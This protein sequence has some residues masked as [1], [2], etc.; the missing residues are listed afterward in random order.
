MSLKS[1]SAVAVWIFLLTLAVVGTIRAQ[2]SG[3][4]LRGTILDTTGATLPEARVSIKNLDTGVS[5]TVSTN[6][7]G[8]YRAVNLIA[9]HYE[10]TATASGFKTSVQ[11]DVT[12]TVGNET[13]LDLHLEVGTA[14]ETINVSSTLPTVDATSSTLSS[15][16]V[17]ETIRELPLNGRD[18]TSLATLQPGI[19]SIQ[20]QASAGSTSSR[21]NRGWGNQLAVSGHRPQENNYRIDGV[22]INDY[23]NGAPGSAGGVNLGAD[24]IAEFSVLQSNYSAE[25]GRTSGGVINAITKSGTNQL[26]GTGYEF[27]RNAIFDAR[28]AFN[29]STKNKPDFSRHQFGGSAGGP[30]IKDKTFL[31]GDYE[32][33]RQNKGVSRVVTVPSQ[34]ARD[35]AVDAIRP[36]LALWPLPDKSLNADTGSRS[37]VNTQNLTENYFTTRI[38]HYFSLKDSL[39]GT[40]FFDDSN[41]LIPDA[42]NNVT[43]PNQS[44]RQ[45]VAIEETHTF[46]KTFLNTIRVGY[47]RTTGV[48]NG[49]GT[50]LNPIAGDPR[51]GTVPGLPLGLVN[52]P[53]VTPLAGLGSN[54]LAMH[55][56][57]S[58]QFYDDAFVNRGRHSMKFGFASEKI[59]YAYLKAL[60]PNGNWTFTSLANFLQNTPNR[61]AV[62]SAQRQPVYVQETIF[63]GYFADD[64]RVIPRLTLNLGLRYEMATRPTEANGRF[65]AIKN[66]YGGPQVPVESF[67]ET[68]PTLRNFAPRLGLA[69]DPF[70][71]GKTSVRA[72]FGMFDVLPLPYIIAPHPAGDYPFL[73][74]TTV[75]NL[76]QGDFPKNAYTKANFSLVAGT[77]RDPNPK[78][79]YAMNWHL[80]LQRELPGQFTATVGYVGSR[81]LHMAFGAEDINTILPVSQGPDGYVWPTSGGQR[82]NTNVSA[83]RAVFFD[84]S[85]TYH[86]LQAQLSR[87]FSRGFQIQGSYTW[88]KCID[89]GS[90]GPRGDTFTNDLPDLLWFDKAHRR[91]LCSFHVA[92]NFV[93]NGLY[94]IPG[95]NGNS[96]AAALFGGWQLGGIF[97]ASTGT[98]FS[99]LQPGDPL[100]TGLED[101]YAFPDRI[102][103]GG[104]AGNPVTGAPSAYIKECFVPPVPG[105]RMGNAGRNSLI[106]PSL[107]TLNAALYKNIQVR[108]RLSFQFRAEL[109][110]ALNHPNYAYPLDTNTLIVDK[111]GKFTGN[112]GQLTSTQI[113]NRQI[114]FGLRARF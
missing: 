23:S 104:C 97:S 66:I 61:V 17:G 12:L 55:R 68:N 57:N 11:K 27:A 80:T 33:I 65:F 13:T 60:R 1:K 22:S 30:L 18:W 74:T 59:L 108:E 88:S 109:F 8:A 81:S 62:A 41:F 110:N 46:T 14:T 101:A 90:S 95:P 9:G 87:Q 85:S 20:S 4:S 70:G 21:G 93:A 15:V 99:V 102:V 36:Y 49:I 43:F 42:L 98:P 72:G 48:A 58:Y 47:N 45:M 106:G 103:T 63:A 31:F 56:A 79:S 71:T 5:T 73:I 54:T 69:W 25:Y 78:R 28:D 113:D 34:S 114:Q 111:T 89:T 40:Y 94:D 37:V 77:Y 67:F 10:V 105:T 84:A 107:V 112:T 53:G 7:S 16:V 29:P 75:R 6:T 44:R 82:L 35:R 96:A 91:G 52:V 83:L 86:G 76:Q 2:V 50:A 32:G 3:A 92:H 100:G 19:L 38:D 39:F 51:L 26:H 24:A 64:W